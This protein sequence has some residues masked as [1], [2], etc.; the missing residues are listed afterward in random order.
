MDHR[1]LFATE[2]FLITAFSISVLSVRADESN[3][4]TKLTFSAPVEIHR[5]NASGMN[6][7]VRSGQQQLQP[8]HRPDLQCRPVDAL[9]HVVYYSQ[10]TLASKRRD[11]SDVCGTTVP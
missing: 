6:V 7:L 1:K 11:H 4:E 3:Q 10:R 2:L 5:P 9:R 8:Q